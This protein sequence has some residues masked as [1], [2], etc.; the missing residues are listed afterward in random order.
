MGPVVDLGQ[1]RPLRLYGFLEQSHACFAQKLGAL[2]LVAVDAGYYAILPGRMSLLAP[3]DN[4]I[5]GEF[6]GA[7]L[8]AAV[9]AGVSVATEQIDA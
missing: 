9:L 8:A 4:V 7:G 5:E 6:L 2:L 3:W 1:E